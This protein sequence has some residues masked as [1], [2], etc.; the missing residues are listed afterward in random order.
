[1]INPGK[2]LLVIL[3]WYTKSTSLP[4]FYLNVSNKKVTNCREN[5]FIPKIIILKF[6]ITYSK[7]SF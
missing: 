1:M 3:L 5:Y 4:K 6:V 2:L 7:Q